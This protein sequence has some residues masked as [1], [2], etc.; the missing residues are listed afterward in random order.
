MPHDLHVIRVGDFVRLDAHGRVDLEGS[1][2]VLAQLAGAMVT[3]GLDR[4]LLDVRG[5][6]GPPLSPL[7]V[8][9][10]ATTFHEA[11]F[12]REHRLAICCN[13]S[14]AANAEFFALVAGNRGWN[15][16]AFETFEEAFEWLTTQTRIA[17]APPPDAGRD[18]D[19]AP[20]SN[21]AT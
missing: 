4:A 10:L 15:V 6:S 3:R 5:I 1:R 7:D 2:A 19:P 13:A 12:R 20:P 11:G 17:P 9:T 21:A 14:R 16:E 18:A 8:Y